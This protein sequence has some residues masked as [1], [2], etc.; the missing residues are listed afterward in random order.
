MEDFQQVVTDQGLPIYVRPTTQ[1]KTITVQ[2]FIDRPFVDDYSQFALLP[3]VLKRGSDEL[4]DSLALE[5]RFDQL[6]G[7]NFEVHTHRLGERHVVELELELADQSLLPDAPPLLQAGLETLA[8]L[9]LRPHLEQGAFSQDYL[10]QEQE[11]QVRAI[12]S[13]FND[14]A[15]YAHQRCLQEMFKGDPYARLPLGESDQVRQVTAQGLRQFHQSILHSANFQLFIT[16]NLSPEEALSLC[17]RIFTQPLGLP[18]QPGDLDRMPAG[19][20]TPL[21]VVEE[22]S[23]AQ[24]KLVLA[25]RTGVSRRDPLLFA[26][27]VYNGILGAFSHS[28]LFQNVRE[29]A[30]LAY[31]CVSQLAAAKGLVLVEAGISPDQV[32]ATRAIIGQQLEC[33]RQGDWSQDEWDKSV[34]ALVNRLRGLA[35]RPDRH[36]LTHLDRVLSGA[37]YSDQEMIDSIQ[38]VTP[39]QVLQVAAGVQLDTAYF[40]RGTAVKE[41]INDERE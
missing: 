2:L 11:S 24:G 38:Q 10:E 30:S 19:R 13:I 32:A 1:F 39:E 20:S 31:Y 8:E 14:K 41:E 22:Q 37:S 4:P 40:L 7:A 17:N 12:Q 36:A 25:Y 33:M 9:L 29:R 18:R 26:L 16:G 35:D 6:Y 5:R 23:V 3:H 15:D 28:K 34:L 21:E 27:M